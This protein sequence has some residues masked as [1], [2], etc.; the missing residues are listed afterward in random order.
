MYGTGHDLNTSPIPDNSIQELKAMTNLDILENVRK[1]TVLPNGL[2]NPEDLAKS[3]LRQILLLVKDVEPET[4]NPAL[5][6]LA[7]IIRK[8]ERNC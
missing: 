1:L 5:D 3:R 8:A 2:V 4:K 6:A 7:E